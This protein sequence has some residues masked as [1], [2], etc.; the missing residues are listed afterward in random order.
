LDGNQDDDHHIVGSDASAVKRPAEGTELTTTLMTS[1][2]VG[3]GFDSKL[4]GGGG[5]PDRLRY[6]VIVAMC[7]GAAVGATLSRITVAPVI[8]LAAAVVAASL[9]IFQFGPDRG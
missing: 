8:G 4:A 1:T 2:I 6:S 3:V 7:G 9:L 5:S